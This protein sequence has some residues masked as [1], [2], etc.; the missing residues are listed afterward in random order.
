M[1]ASMCATNARPHEI[2]DA[3]LEWEWKVGRVEGMRSDEIVSS[4]DSEAELKSVAN[5]RLKLTVCASAGVAVQ[6]SA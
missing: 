3:R 5:S 6:T 1:T 2:K 4:E